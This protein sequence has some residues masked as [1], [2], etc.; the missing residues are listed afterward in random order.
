MYCRSQNFASFSEKLLLSCRHRVGRVVGI[1]TPPTPHPRASV[2]PPPL[3][4]GG[5]AHSL[6]REGVGE[7]QFRRGNIHCGT[8]YT[9]IYVLSTTL[10]LQAYFE[11]MMDVAVLLGAN[12]AAAEKEMTEVL[13]FEIAIANISLP[14]YTPEQFFLDNFLKS[15][16]PTTFRSTQ[17]RYQLPIIY[18]YMGS[19]SLHQPQNYIC[20]F[21]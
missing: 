5:G 9:R 6:A 10:C 11:Y 7:S 8:L 18:L 19:I 12:P 2:P 21:P 17:L 16:L 13:L 20:T 4:P 3:V 15:W 1:E 14:R